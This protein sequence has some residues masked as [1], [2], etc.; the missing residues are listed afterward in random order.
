MVALPSVAMGANI[1]TGNGSGNQFL[2]MRYV[3]AL[4]ITRGSLNKSMRDRIKGMKSNT[5]NICRGGMERME[6]NGLH[7]YEQASVVT[8]RK[9][10]KR[11]GVELHYPP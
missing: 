1:Q 2:E 3:R 11:W 4:W 8:P 9:V 10:R 6:W 7:V 5:V